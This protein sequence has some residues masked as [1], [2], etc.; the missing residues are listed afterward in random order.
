MSE[1]NKQDEVNPNEMNITFMDIMKIIG[2]D[3]TCENDKKVYIFL[4]NIIM[5]LQEKVD[6]LSVSKYYSNEND[7]KYDK[8]NGVPHGLLS[9]I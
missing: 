2:S 8:L 9:I 1:E 6:K 4:L 7:F 5:E 3:D